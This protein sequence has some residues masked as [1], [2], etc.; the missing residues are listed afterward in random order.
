RKEHYE[1]YCRNGVSKIIGT[2]LDR[3]F[4]IEKQSYEA[5]QIWT[6]LRNL[7][8]HQGK[9]EKDSIAVKV[10]QNED[11][12]RQNIILLAFE[13]LKSLEEIYRVSW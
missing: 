8:F 12:L 3:Y 2:L 7:N 11:D 10:L 5:N 1:C 6:W 13:G 4:E 9:N